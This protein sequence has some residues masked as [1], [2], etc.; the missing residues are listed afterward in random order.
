MRR[1][2][3]RFVNQELG[4]FLHTC[5]L[6]AK[7]CYDPKGAVN[8]LAKLGAHEHDQGSPMMNLMRTHPMTKERVVKV[9]EEMPKA[10]DLYYN[11]GCGVADE[12]FT[13]VGDMFR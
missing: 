6:M 7:A 11:S 4:A 2:L 10:Y 8:M 9:K 3:D 5:R 13:I 1:R 12:F